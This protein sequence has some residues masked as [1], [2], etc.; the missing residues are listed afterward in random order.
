MMCVR[1]IPAKSGYKVY[2]TAVRPATVYGA[3]CWAVSN[4]GERTLHPTEMRMWRWAGGKTRLDHVSN[5][6]IWKEAHMYPIAEFRSGTGRD[7][8]DMC[9]TI[10]QR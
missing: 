3:E 10:G 7:G 1:N 5:V 4:K 9:S 6:D 2:K 8:L